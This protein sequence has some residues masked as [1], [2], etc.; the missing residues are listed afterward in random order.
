MVLNIFCQLRLI[1]V[2]LSF[3]L[4]NLVCAVSPELDPLL[5]ADEKLWLTRHAVI[6]LGIDSTFAPFE[7][8][9]SKGV[10]SGLAADYVYILE[11]RIG[12]K[13][14]H[15]T[16]LSWSAILDAVK[17][18]EVDLVPAIFHLRERESF[19]NFTSSIIELPTAIITPQNDSQITSIASLT[20]KRVSVVK[21]WAFVDMIMRYPG[22]IV[23]VADSVE[24]ALAAVSFG[25]VDAYL[26]DLA[27]ATHAINRVGLTN[28]KV[29]GYM[30]QKSMLCMAVRKDWPELTS[31]INK[32]LTTFSL[33]TKTTINDRWIRLEDKLTIHD[34]LS[35][36]IPTLITTTILTL[37]AVN[38]RL[39]REIARRTKSESELSNARNQLEQR[40]LDRTAELS[41]ALNN[42]KTLSGLLPICSKCKKVRD[43]QG[44]WKAIDEYITQ[45]SDAEFSHG[46]CPICAQEM[47]PE[48]FRKE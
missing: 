19:V 45:H 31:I 43:D 34:I 17:N 21:D 2:L 20:G 23:K 30:P 26:G 4:V 25:E 14:Q 36:L 38:W 5:S 24:E 47:Y 8:I 11:Q 18:R 48:Y 40:V 46:L 42:V 22:V 32:A 44:Y 33:E 29:A 10:Y 13:M 27:T 16:T 39:H 9:D 1:L 35:I 12:I 15:V 41:A 6:K 37:L 3:C 28:L 7:M